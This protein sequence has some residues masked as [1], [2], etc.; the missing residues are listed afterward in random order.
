MTS[1]LA[2]TVLAGFVLVAVMVAVMV[3][4]LVFLPKKANVAVVIPAGTVTPLT[5]NCAT[6]G[7]S[8]ERLTTRPL[9]GA[10]LLIVT[11]PAEGESPLV[12]VAGFRMRLLSTGASSGLL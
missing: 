6:L 10:G 12:I 3:T 9:D 8:L 11:V 1:T 7:L 5:E 4:L 2:D